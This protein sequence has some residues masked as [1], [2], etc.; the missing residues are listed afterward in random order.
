MNEVRKKAHLRSVVFSLHDVLHDHPVLDLEMVVHF[1][2]CFSKRVLLR[3]V[4][5]TASQKFLNASWG[6]GSK[7]GNE[8]EESR[9]R[10]GATKESR[11]L[12]QA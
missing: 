7:S 3:E 1:V 5:V 11:D 12:D 4:F 6:R 10:G 8:G 9:W 2:K